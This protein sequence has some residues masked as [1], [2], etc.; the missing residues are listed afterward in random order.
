MGPFNPSDF[1]VDAYIVSDKLA[2]QFK[3]GTRWMDGRK[4]SEIKDLSKSLEETFKTFPGY[5][6]DKPFTFRIWSTKEFAK[7]VQ[8]TGGYKNF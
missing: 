8:P 6:A 1:D 5:R 2:S 3:N 7:R 4:I